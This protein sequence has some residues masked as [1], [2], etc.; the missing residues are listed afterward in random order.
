MKILEPPTSGYN[1]AMLSLID[2]RREGKAV[3]AS[4]QKVTRVLLFL[5]STF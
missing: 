3:I 1:R 2:G 5:I 4:A